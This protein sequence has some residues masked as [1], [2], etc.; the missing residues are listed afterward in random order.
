MIPVHLKKPSD[1]PP[2]TTHYVIARNGLFLSKKEWWV[3][4]VVP[5]KQIAVLDDQEVSA[6]LLMPPLTTAVFTKALKVARR[7]YEISKSE[8]CML[9][10]YHKETGYQLIMPMQ[11]VSPGR[12]KYDASERLPGHL[13]VGTIHSHG[14]LTASHS[15]TDHQDEIYWDGIHITV[16]DMASYPQFSLSA[17]IVING[18]RFPA[19]ICWLEGL[20]RVPHSRLY[21]LDQHEGDQWEIPE[22]WLARV[23]QS[24][25]LRF[26]LLKGGR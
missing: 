23:N 20:R 5:V 17:E 22:E 11:S 9:L 3:E 19:D 14:G 13:P 26:S 6:R 4:A 24:R 7:I 15:S 2:T 25:R 8:V 10:H 1:S 16:G 21:L 18:V 12:V